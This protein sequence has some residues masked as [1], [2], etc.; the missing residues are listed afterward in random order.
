MT[1]WGALSECSLAEVEWKGM[2]L[3]TG[4]TTVAAGYDRRL[5]QTPGSLG[6]IGYPPP[7]LT[8]PLT[9][10]PSPPSCSGIQAELPACV[11][12]VV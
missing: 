9:P 1:G 6:R 7:P 10:P 11:A 2:R 8:P 3:D 5:A 12:P 4:G